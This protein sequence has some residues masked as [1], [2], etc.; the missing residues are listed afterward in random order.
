DWFSKLTLKEFN[1][2]YKELVNEIPDDIGIIAPPDISYTEKQVRGW[3]HKAFSDA[4]LPYIKPIVPKEIMSN[5][6]RSALK[7]KGYTYTGITSSG[8]NAYVLNN[9]LRI[10][11]DTLAESKG[12]FSLH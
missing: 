7:P 12:R 4:L 8:A 1:I 11:L 5:E 3:I 10:I 6:E 2:L 9:G